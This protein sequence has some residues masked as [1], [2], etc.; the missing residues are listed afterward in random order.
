M[1]T[2]ATLLMC[3]AISADAFVVS[4]GKGLALKKID[5]R[6]VLTVSI[7]FGAFHAIMPLIG[8]LAGTT[9]HEFIDIYDN[10]V[11]FL[12][13]LILGIMFIREGLQDDEDNGKLSKDPTVRTMFPLAI[14]TSLDA[15]AAGVFFSKCDRRHRRH[16]RARSHRRMRKCCRTVPRR[17]VR[18]KIRESRHNCRRLPSIIYRNIGA[19][20]G[21][22][23]R[24]FHERLIY[25]GTKSIATPINA[26]TIPVTIV[27]VLSDSSSK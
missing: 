8:W 24:S 16:H 26:K 19:S 6:A 12:V 22:R 21:I 11:M 20:R 27:N 14:A 4:L 2:W 17:K 23:Y 15:L 5:K 18:Y 9:F 13:M 1:I 25:L 3:V 10:W 7:W